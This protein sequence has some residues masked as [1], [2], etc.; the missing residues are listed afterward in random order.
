[1]DQIFNVAVVIWVYMTIVFILA[2]LRKD[3]S[4]VDFFWGLGFILI[5]VY[6]WI[7]EDHFSFHNV[8]LNVLVILWGLRLS[9]HIFFR[10][11]G[12]PE[13]FRYKSWREQWN[14]F[15]LRS[16]FQIF[17]LQGFLMLIISIPLY[18]GNQY[19]KDQFGF[20]DFCGLV[21]FIA[22]FWFESV[23]DY[24]LNIFKRNPENQGKLITNGLWKYTRHPNYFGE[25][26]VWCGIGIFTLSSQAGWMTL[27]SPVVITLLLRFVSGVPMLEKKYDGRPDW[28]EYKKRTAAFF[29]FVRFL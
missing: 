14:Y 13:D 16:Y 26:L 19:D 28:E 2:I 18:F 12:K 24:Q 7:H 6:S 21:I 10:N 9:M 8:V 17:M 15:Y 23:G 5:S 20:T 22:G 3:N 1:M 4:I 25:V 27:I 11:R 29:P